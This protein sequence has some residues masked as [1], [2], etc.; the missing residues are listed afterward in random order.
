VAQWY[1]PCD[2]DC[3]EY[4]KYLKDL[5]EDPMSRHAPVDEIM[6]NYRKRHMKTCEKCQEYG[7]ANIGIARY[8]GG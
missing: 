2:P 8:I 6:E 4:S 5:I 3:P 1:M 7:V